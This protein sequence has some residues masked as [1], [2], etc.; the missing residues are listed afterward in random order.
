LAFHVN[1]DEPGIVGEECQGLYLIQQ[2][3]GK[4]IIDPANIAYFKFA[5]SWIKLHF[6]GDTIFWRRS[7]IPSEPVNDN[8]SNCLALLNLCELDG[9][10]GYALNSITYDGGK[11]YVGVKLEFSSHKT[12]SFKHHD[13]DDYTTIDC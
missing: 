6:D 7:D 11:D 9:V 12:L 3:E 2:Q 10:V 8:L 13:F 1:G 4:S 5:G